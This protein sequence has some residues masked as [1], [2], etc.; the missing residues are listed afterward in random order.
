[1]CSS[2]LPTARRLPRMESAARR[3]GVA[4][5]RDA[6]PAAVRS[7]VMP[8]AIIALGAN[9]GQPVEALR[10]AVQ[11]LGRTDGIRVLGTSR[12]YTTSPVESSGPDYV[13]AAVLVETT[14]E[15][16]A[17]LRA[18][19][20]IENAHGR[21]RPAGVVNAPRTLDLDVIAY[22]GTVSADPVL[23]LPHPRLHDRLFVLVPI[24]DLLPD[25]RLPD[26]RTVGEAVRDVREAHPDQLI[27]PLG[28]ENM[29]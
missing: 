16:M 20:A 13:N 2:D 9:L 17:L 15:P 3:E 11:A 8:E 12:F 25:W 26:G 22:E 19:Q 5:R 14:L 29:A 21:V 24:A 10:S 6:P 28:P 1:V 4:V 27:R 18:C 7:A 23:T